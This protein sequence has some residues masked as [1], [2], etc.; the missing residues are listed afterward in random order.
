MIGTMTTGQI[1]PDETSVLFYPLWDR[2]HDEGLDLE[3]IQIYGSHD[4]NGLDR[5]PTLLKTTRRS[6]TIGIS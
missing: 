3:A 4:P 6:T 1:W 5:G 2:I